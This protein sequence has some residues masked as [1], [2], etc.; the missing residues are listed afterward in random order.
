MK[1]RTSMKTKK[2]LGLAALLL[3]LTL[4]AFPNYAAADTAPTPPPPP[5]PKVVIELTRPT[6]KAPMVYMRVVEV[7]ETVSSVLLP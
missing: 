3:T 5:P 1:R 4:S 6:G 7:V 2:T